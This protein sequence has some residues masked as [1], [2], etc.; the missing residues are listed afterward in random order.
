MKKF[1]ASLAVFVSLSVV[2]I[3]KPVTA[4][5]SPSEQAVSYAKQNQVVL[6]CRGTG[7]NGPFVAGGQGA[8]MQV[9]QTGVWIITARHVSFN[10]DSCDAMFP[11]YSFHTAYL[12]KQY[13]KADVSILFVPK[14]YWPTQASIK[15]VKL[16]E[17]LF[18]F[19]EIKQ[20]YTMVGD[21][22]VG[23]FFDFDYTLHIGKAYS[24]SPKELLDKINYP[25][26]ADS[27]MLTDLYSA[28]GSSGGGVY[29]A[30]GNLVGLVSCGD[31]KGHT[32]IVDISKA[33][34]EETW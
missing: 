18:V 26:P 32:F 2:L 17:D 6:T 11:D 4:S 23:F 21:S 29:D 22:I 30:D 16:F 27:A 28:P 3:S 24:Y 13:N 19:T 12:S 25:V 7:E 31:M 1:L 15:P 8:I 34:E 33:F 14:A 5:Y 20:K 9:D 10:S